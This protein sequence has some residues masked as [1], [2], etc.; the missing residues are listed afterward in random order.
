M[1]V[2]Q[3]MTTQIM[4]ATLVLSV[5]GDGVYTCAPLNLSQVDD[6]CHPYAPTFPKATC[7][8]ATGYPRRSKAAFEKQLRECSTARSQRSM[9]PNDP[10]ECTTQIFSKKE[11]C[12]V[13][14]QQCTR[15]SD[16]LAYCYAD[17]FPCNTRAN[18]DTLVA[19][20]VVAEEGAPC[21][22]P[23]N[24]TET[25]SPPPPFDGVLRA[26]GDGRLDA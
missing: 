7:V 5:A 18:C 2:T 21:Y 16:C 1:L 3:M 4:M 19:F 6:F 14:D 25:D 22:S 15:D 12:G 13:Y 20:G 10:K 26:G 8:D 17:C 23:R 24:H 9:C 11:Y